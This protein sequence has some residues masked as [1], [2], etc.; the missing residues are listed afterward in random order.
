[1][2]REFME[3]LCRKFSAVGT[4]SMDPF[5]FYLIAADILLILHVVVVLFIVAGLL[6]ILAGGL[7]HWSW[8]RNPWFRL[9]H[10]IAIGV[11]VVQAW[12]G[13]ICPLTVWEQALRRQAGD[14]AYSGSFIVHWLDKLLYYEAPIWVFALCYT[15]FG[16]AVAAAW[17]RVRPR[18]F[19]SGVR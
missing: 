5:S 2:C 15:L 4:E 11:V 17:Y 7:W 16:A 6:L 14:S 12:A 18:A 19:H 13:A 1:M 3:L 9:A 8:V 10:V